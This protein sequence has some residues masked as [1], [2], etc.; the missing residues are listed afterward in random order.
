MNVMSQYSQVFALR[1]WPLNGRTASHT[2][3][4]GHLRT[5]TFIPYRGAFSDIK[6]WPEGTQVMWLKFSSS[7]RFVTAIKKRR[8]VTALN[9]GLA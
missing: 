8:P 7:Q 4:C 6:G 1:S 9:G 3:H 5:H 2:L